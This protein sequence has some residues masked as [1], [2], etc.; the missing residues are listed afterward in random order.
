MP[1]VPAGK[2]LLELGVGLVQEALPLRHLPNGVASENGVTAAEPFFHPELSRVVDGMSVVPPIRE[3][4]ER[5]VGPQQL[6]PRCTGPVQAGPWNQP[7]K[8]IRDVGR[9]VVNRRLIALRHGRPVLARNSVE[10]QS[11][12]REVVAPIADVRSFDQKTAGQFALKVD[13]P[14]LR[15]PVLSLYIPETQSASEEGRKTQTRSRGFGD[16][17]R[18][19]VIEVGDERDARVERGYDVGGLAE[20]ILNI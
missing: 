11:V 14:A 19:R 4:R 7:C 20:T 12:D 16:S 17:A 1:A 15:V 5:R 3:S 10:D 6:R 8:R 9:E 13:R 18:K 2:S